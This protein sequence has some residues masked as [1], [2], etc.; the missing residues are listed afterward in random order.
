MR[1]TI[2]LLLIACLS[3]VL[4]A[5]SP[6]SFATRLVDVSFEPREPFAPIESSFACDADSCYLGTSGGLFRLPSRVEPGAVAELVAFEGREIRNVYV[7]DGA[8]YVLKTGLESGNGPAT[9][10]T[11]FRSSD[12]GA[13]FVPLDDGL[14]ECFGGY[15]A[16]LS[17][18]EAAFQG[19]TIFTNAGGNLVASRDGG[20]WVPLVGELAR[21]ACYDP[22]FAVS[23]NRVLVGGECPLDDAY[24]RHGMLREGLLEWELEPADAVTPELENRNVQFIR[25]IDGGPLVLA[26]IEGAILRSTDHGA[27]W[28]YV[29]FHDIEDGVLYPY[30]TQLLHL[31]DS[32]AFLAGG[33][34][35]A[36]MRPWLAWSDDEGRTWKDIST[37]VTSDAA[38]DV[39]VFLHRD[40]EGRV[41]SGLLDVEGLVVRIV[42]LGSREP[43]RRPARR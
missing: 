43:R 35:K 30:I 26:G 4:C 27:S 40:G 12:G 18:S 13:T 14:E 36:N 16:Y 34:D 28:E 33:F 6:P 10:R 24:V 25:V 7:H 29:Y 8:I 2:A 15:C 22:T 3:P 11:F 37:V 19:D 41:L 9:D 21:Q 17:A 23:G 1:L 38:F 31:P 5:D 32:G 42:E 39:L 20:S